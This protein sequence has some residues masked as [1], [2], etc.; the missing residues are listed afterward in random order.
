MRITSYHG[1]SALNF[2]VQTVSLVRFSRRILRGSYFAAVSVLVPA[3]TKG[4]KLLA[5][6]P[7]VERVDLVR[8]DG[9][10]A[11]HT[12]YLH[13]KRQSNHGRVRDKSGS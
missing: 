6:L 1:H 4:I 5:V 8:G 10:L 9:F 7:N 13:R 2:G 11:S 3:L 12:I